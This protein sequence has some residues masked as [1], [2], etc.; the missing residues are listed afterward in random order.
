MRLC[1][2]LLFDRSKYWVLHA[3]E[4]V[5][6]PRPEEAPAVETENPVVEETVD[7]VTEEATTEVKE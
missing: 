3:K 5:A 7:T 6:V 2:S 1:A 4:N